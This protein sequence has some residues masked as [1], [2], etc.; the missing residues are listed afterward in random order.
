M[1]ISPH[2][3]MWSRDFP[4]SLDIPPYFIRGICCQPNLL[5]QY[6]IHHDL[7]HPDAVLNC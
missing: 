5:H 7:E 2:F 3:F 6:E 1:H 4:L